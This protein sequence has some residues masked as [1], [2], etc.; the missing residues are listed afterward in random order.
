MVSNL[1]GKN[2]KIKIKKKQKFSMK[3]SKNPLNSLQNEKITQKLKIV[4]KCK[5]KSIK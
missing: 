3:Y 2:L 1:L 5:K 4:K